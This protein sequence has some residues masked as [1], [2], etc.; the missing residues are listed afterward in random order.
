MEPKGNQVTETKRL[1]DAIWD[2]DVVTV[3]TLIAAGAD[4]NA[5]TADDTPPL[6]WLAIEQSWPEIV[7]LLVAAGADVNRYPGSGWGTP[8][9]HAI[10]VES[11]TAWQRRDDPYR[12]S[13]ELTELLLAAGAVPAEE[14]FAK[15]QDYGN[16]QVLTLLQQYSQRSP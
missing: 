9:A 16:R 12:A 5:A 8:L 11:D 6:L 7:R 10:D 4:V 2:R 3:V 14:A 13:T 15:A 1:A